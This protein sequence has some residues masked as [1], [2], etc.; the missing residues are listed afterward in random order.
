M[1]ARP[2]TVKVTGNLKYDIRAPK[3]SRIAELV[4]EAAAGRPIVVAGSTVGGTEDRDP[5]EEGWI[6]TAWG[7]GARNLDALL[8]IA[9]RHP[10]RFELVW[11]DV[12]EFPALRATEMLSK[13][14]A[15]R[16]RCE[17]VEMDATKAEIVLL[18]TI[19]DLATVYGIADVA[20]VG[21][22]LLRRGGHN[23]LEPAQWGVPIVIGPS[24]E[25][26]RDIVATLRVANGITVVAGSAQLPTDYAKKNV[27]RP[28]LYVMRD[29]LTK[30]LLNLLTDRIA[31]RAM[32]ERGRKVFEQQQGATARSVDALVAMIHSHRGEK[33]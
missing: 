28:D 24:F 23:P 33:P 7:G 22:S 10:E 30:E 32:G 29:S 4:R 11:K 9:P 21:G 13:G 16:T 27:L 31:A 1:G 5:D 20:F 8:V 15:I 18:D 6:I 25:N 19:G 17:N 14:E 2:E 3:H 12:I 26:F